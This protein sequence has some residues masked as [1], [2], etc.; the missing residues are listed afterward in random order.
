MEG[1][2]I[3]NGVVI[4][5]SGNETEIVIPNGV[6]SIG[7][8]AFLGCIKL[9]SIIIPDGVTMIGNYAFLGCKELTSIVIPDSVER[10]G[11]C[12]FAECSGLTSV[13][14]DSVTNIG[15]DAFY[16]CDKLIRSVNAKSLYIQAISKA[17]ET[18]TGEKL[19]DFMAK[20]GLTNLK[21]A[22]LEQ[23]SEYAADNGII[24]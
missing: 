13:V 9:T 2:E 18:E 6:T 19:L 17:S 22:T 11:N 4:G 7:S 15:N 3:K 14:L 8:Y 1:L 12:A 21:E 10:I 23:L 16:G 5:Y 20:F 24:I